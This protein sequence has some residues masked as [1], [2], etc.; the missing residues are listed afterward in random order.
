[1]VR[2]KFGLEAAQAYL[3]HANIQTTQIYAER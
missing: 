2:E 3:G 1:M